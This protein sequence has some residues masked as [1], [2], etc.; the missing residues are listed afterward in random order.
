MIKPAGREKDP[1]SGV[2]RTNY[3]NDEVKVTK[4]ISKMNCSVNNIK[5]EYNSNMRIPKNY[6]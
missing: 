6:I 3:N 5:K 1:N 4:I 2:V